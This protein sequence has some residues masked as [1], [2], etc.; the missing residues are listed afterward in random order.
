MIAKA[1]EEKKKIEEIRDGFQTVFRYSSFNDGI[2]T[3]GIILW[4]AID[5]ANGGIHHGYLVTKHDELY[6][7]SSRRDM[8]LLTGLKLLC[9]MEYDEMQITLV[10]DDF[11]IPYE[12]AS[13]RSWKFYDYVL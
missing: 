10:P 12:H 7:Y 3:E 8:N 5:Y 11:E 4:Y 9:S 2:D 13:C 6:E 1:N